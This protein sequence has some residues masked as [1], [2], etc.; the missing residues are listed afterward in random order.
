MVSYEF[1][2]TTYLS[3]QESCPL[4]GS[5]SHTKLPW[6]LLNHYTWGRILQFLILPHCPKPWLTRQLKFYWMIF[7]FYILTTKSFNISIFLLLYIATASY[8][9]SIWVL[10]SILV[11]KN[12]LYLHK[13]NIELIFIFLVTFTSNLYLFDFSFP[14]FWHWPFKKKCDAQVYFGL[15][16]KFSWNCKFNSISLCT[17]TP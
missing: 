1:S 12:Y 2:K 17:S 10:K 6:I 13:G 3:N 9:I 15:C 5:S 8:V 14:K 11:K 4:S 7:C 16:L